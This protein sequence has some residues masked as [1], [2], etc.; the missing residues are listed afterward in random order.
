M[1]VFAQRDAE[2]DRGDVFEAV[3]PFFSF[4][5]LAA[6]VEHA[7]FAVRFCELQRRVVEITNCMLSWPMVNLVSYIPVVFVLALR[8]SGSV[9]M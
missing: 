9:G 6:H 7:N 5:A 2:D 4:A 3:D 1:V 8:T